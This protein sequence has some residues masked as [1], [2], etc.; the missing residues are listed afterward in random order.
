MPEGMRVVRKRR[1]KRDEASRQTLILK[2]REIL[3]EMND[4]SAAV[5]VKEQVERLKSARRAKNTDKPLEEHWGGRSSSKKGAR[6]VLLYTFAL[7]IPVLAICTA[8]LLIQGGEVGKVNTPA[9]ELVFTVD[10]EE[11]DIDVSSGPLAWFIEDPHG[12]YEDA[13]ELLDRLNAADDA[14]LPPEL[15]R[16]GETTI[17]RIAEEGLGWESD[18][19]TADPRTFTWK[20]ATAGD[21]G[22]LI[23]GGVRE[24][25]RPFRTYLVHTPKG[26]RLDWEATTGW[27]EWS[28]DRLAQEDPGRPIMIRARIFKE[29]HFDTT[30][31]SDSDQSCYLLRSPDNENHLWGFTETD[32]P[33]D[34]KLR[35]FFG[36]GGFVVERVPEV[37]ATLRISKL[38]GGLRGNEYRIDEVISREWVVPDEEADLPDS[39]V[40]RK[41]GG[42]DDAPAE[43]GETSVPVPDSEE[44]GEQ[45]DDRGEEDTSPGGRE[46]PSTEGGG[47]DNLSEGAAHGIEGTPTG[48]PVLEGEDALV[49]EE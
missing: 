20:T 17:A 22:Y 21:T 13:I 23:Y 12:A 18:F 44:D 30:G 47:A 19:S 32:G 11:P 34:R 38:D 29:E 46:D 24:D 37:L 49:E 35:D 43:E 2:K 28:Y 26:L 36:Y 33:I 25:Q 10:H 6:W 41:S 9:D 45:I 3:R 40:D 5:G 15:F 4:E 31:G 16:R 27:S 42:V 1:K 8:F 48:E 39:P 7:L 14:K